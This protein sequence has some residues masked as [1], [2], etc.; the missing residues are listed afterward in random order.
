MEEIKTEQLPG[1]LNH[2][3]VNSLAKDPEKPSLQSDV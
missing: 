2:Q 3:H 1:F